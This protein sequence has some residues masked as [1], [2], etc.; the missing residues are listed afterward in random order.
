MHVCHRQPKSQLTQAD[1]I[2]KPNNA[3]GSNLYGNE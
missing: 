2:L 1:E 3:Q